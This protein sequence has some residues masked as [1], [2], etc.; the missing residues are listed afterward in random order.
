MLVTNQQTIA[1]G[2]VRKDVPHKFK[3]TIRNNGP[4]SA[5]IKNITVGCGSCTQA[6]M[7]KNV[8]EVEGTA[9]V[10]VIFTPTSTGNQLKGLNIEYITYNPEIG[11]Q[12][13]TYNIALKFSAEVQ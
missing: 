3:Y 8:L 6:S 7:D 1:L 4:A 5:T 2:K 11:N 12:P 10:H 13:L 9:E